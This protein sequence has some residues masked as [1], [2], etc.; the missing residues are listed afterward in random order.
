MTAQREQTEEQL[1]RQCEE[2]RVHNQQELQQV[3]E[4]QARL[5]QDFNQRLLQA[6]S[7][8]QQVC[9]LIALILL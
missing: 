9:V 7:E 2:L 1:R 5:Q 3:Q 6:E 8:K 4:E